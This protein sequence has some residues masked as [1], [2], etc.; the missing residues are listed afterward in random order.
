[1]QYPSTQYF[2]QRYFISFLCFLQ[3]FDY[4]TEKKEKKKDNKP[5]ELQAVESL[6]I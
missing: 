4:K 3:S 1:M 6:L 2:D 5:F